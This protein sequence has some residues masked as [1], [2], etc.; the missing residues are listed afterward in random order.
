M[1]QIPVANNLLAELADWQQ[2]AAA[3]P[4]LVATIIALLQKQGRKSVTLTA[5]QLEQAAAF[6]LELK[7]TDGKRRLS[8]KETK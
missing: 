1:P 8:V 2:K 6:T 7:D 4:H 3:Y 5:R